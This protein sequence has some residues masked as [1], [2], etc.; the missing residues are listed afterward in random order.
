MEGFPNTGNI[1]KQLPID[2]CTFSVT[3]RSATATFCHECHVLVVMLHDL[4]NV[5]EKQ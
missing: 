5:M 4:Y 1:P 3:F 2:T